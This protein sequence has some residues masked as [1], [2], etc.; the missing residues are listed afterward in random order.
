MILE[1]VLAAVTEK[2]GLSY[3]VYYGAGIIKYQFDNC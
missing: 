2:V 3:R 1:T